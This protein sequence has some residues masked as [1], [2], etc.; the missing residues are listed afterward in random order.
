VQ[1]SQVTLVTS[2]L[3]I[4]GLIFLA[5]Q[6]LMGCSFDPCAVLELGCRPP[7]PPTPLPASAAQA[8]WQPRVDGGAVRAAPADAGSGD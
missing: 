1:R 8:H 3:A 4:V 6:L 2:L 5:A 7:P